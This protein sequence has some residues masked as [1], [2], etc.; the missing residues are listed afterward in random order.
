MSECGNSKE[1]E[2]DDVPKLKWKI[3]SASSSSSLQL[4]CNNLMQVM[5]KCH[6]SNV[7][8]VA[9][10]GGATAATRHFRFCTAFS[11][12]AFRRRIYDAV[13]CGG[14]S[15]FRHRYEDEGMGIDQLT[16]G[17]GSASEEPPRRQKMANGKSEK[18]VDL[19]N[20]AESVEPEDGVET[21]KKEE[22]LEELK[23]TV[24]DLQVE[25]LARRKAAASNVRL[26]AKEDLV[27]RPTLALLGAIPPLVA[28]LDLED[29]EIQI[30][31]LY[32]LLNLGIGNNA[33]VLYDLI[34]LPLHSW[35]CSLFCLEKFPSHFVLFHVVSSMHFSV[36]LLNP[37]ISISPTFSIAISVSV[38]VFSDL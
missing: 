35:F 20:L 24:R 25:D 23:S 1:E 36:D 10:A 8:S 18:L 11:G 27:I 7:G 9:V 17:S 32:A 15:R 28:M 4:Q 14:S 37:Y 22:A 29:E 31:A 30:A 13:S 34:S 6:S 12:A 38:N 21:R 2:E 3:L 33:W 5:A 19:L 26:L 16:S